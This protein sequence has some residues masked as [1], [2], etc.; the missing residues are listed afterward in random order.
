MPKKT[1]IPSIS[2]ERKALFDEA[3]ADEL[4][5][6][7]IHRELYENDISVIKKHAKKIGVPFVDLEVTGNEIIK[8]HIKNL[9]DEREHCA[10]L[11]FA[12]EKWFDYFQYVFGVSLS[13]YWEGNR[14]GLDACRLDEEAIKPPDGTSTYDFVREKHGEQAVQ[15]LKELI[16]GIP[17]R[18]PRI[19]VL[20]EA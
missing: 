4:T 1:K 5:A 19:E 15:M 2:P 8:R 17:D 13:K 11:A 6:E 10:S 12:R 16:H 9:A 3:G 14:Y 18:Q 7:K 20:N